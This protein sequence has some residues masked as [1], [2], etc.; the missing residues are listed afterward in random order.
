MLNEAQ[1]HMNQLRETT[2]CCDLSSFWEA[3]ALEVGK[4]NKV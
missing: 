1:K 4:Q 3:P 2:G